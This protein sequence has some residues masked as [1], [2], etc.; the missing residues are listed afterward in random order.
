MPL[1][2]GQR[3]AQ[4]EVVSPLGS[5]DMGEVYRA[6]DL[7]LDREVAIKVMAEPLK[8]SSTAT[9]RLEGTKKRRR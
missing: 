1:S 6:R 2:P 3:L 7:R 4:H 8:A 9:K 5:G